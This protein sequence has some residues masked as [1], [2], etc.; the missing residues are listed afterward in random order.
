MAAEPKESARKLRRVHQD[1]AGRKIF[2]V[3]PALA[4]WSIAT[5]K[6]PTPVR[7]WVGREWIAVD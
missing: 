7:R 4:A 3:G 5:N 6:K 2:A 1:W